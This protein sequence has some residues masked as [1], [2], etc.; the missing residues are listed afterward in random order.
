MAPIGK[1]ARSKLKPV[2]WTDDHDLL[3]MR[4]MVLSDL[5]LFEK[6]SPNG[7]IVWDSIVENVN[8]IENPV[9]RLKDKRSVRD[10]RTLL[11][12]KYKKKTKGEETANGVDM[13]DFT[14]K[15][16]LIVEFHAKKTTLLMSTQVVNKKKD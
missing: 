8:R 16:S 5:F 6:G 12:T 14:R 2:E 10:R 7:G 3:L 11:K 9:F 4:E 1:P 15:N 13:A